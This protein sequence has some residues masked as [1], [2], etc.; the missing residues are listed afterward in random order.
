MPRPR[1]PP[2]IT[3]TSAAEPDAVLMRKPLRAPDVGEGRGALR[4]GSEVDGE[5]ALHAGALAVAPDDRAGGRLVGSGQGREQVL[6]EEVQPVG[7]APS[8]AG[9]HP[10]SLPLILGEVPVGRGEPGAG[11]EDGFD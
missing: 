1:I 5:A 6:T 10:E 8:H 9:S 11:I 4:I 3:T 2:P 7:E